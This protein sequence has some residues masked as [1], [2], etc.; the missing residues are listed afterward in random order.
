MCARTPRLLV[1]ATLAIAVWAAHAW[2]V[3]AQAANSSN[4]DRLLLGTWKLNLAKSKY[5]SGPPPQSQT[6]IYEPQGQGV[7]A[8]ITT[9]HPDGRS[10]TVGYVANYDSLEYP[11]TG[12]SESDTIA[13][14]KIAPRTAEAVMSHAGRVM[15]TARRII[16]EDGQTLTI[17]YKGESQGQQV[18][19]TA[20]YEKQK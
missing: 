9:I 2:P 3:A 1:S 5:R 11:V 10:T 17:E 13:L 4:E 19:Y 14:K 12:S 20:V 7:K 15:A 6:R 18:N 8:T 16:S